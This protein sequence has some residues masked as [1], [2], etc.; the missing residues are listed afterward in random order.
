MHPVGDHGEENADEASATFHAQFRIPECLT[1]EDVRAIRDMTL[2]KRGRLS[3]Q[4]V[5]LEAY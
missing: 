3:V 2:L 5:S 1:A 4:A